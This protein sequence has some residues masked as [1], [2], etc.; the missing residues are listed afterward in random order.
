MEHMGSMH[1]SGKHAEKMMKGCKV[2]DKVCMRVHG[3]VTSMESRDSL[4]AMVGPENKPSKKSSPEYSM[5][6]DIESVADEKEKD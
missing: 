3:R 1:V 6:V 4:G 5:G 2:G